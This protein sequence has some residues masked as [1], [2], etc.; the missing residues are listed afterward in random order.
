M[1]HLLIED[2]GVN[3]IERTILF[4]YSSNYYT[5]NLITFQVIEDT[6]FLH[7]VSFRCKM[8]FK[9]LITSRIHLCLN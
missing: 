3:P 5:K 6:S 8:Q 2:I 7:P 1:K 4:K 9:T